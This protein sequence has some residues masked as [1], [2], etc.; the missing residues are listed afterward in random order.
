MSTCECSSSS[1]T[2]PPF[3]STDTP[4]HAPSLNPE[5]CPHPSCH[6]FEHAEHGMVRTHRLPSASTCYNMLKRQLSDGCRLLIRA[7]DVC[8][9]APHNSRCCKSIT[10]KPNPPPRVVRR[11]CPT[12]A[13]QR[14]CVR[15][16]CMPSPRAPASS[17]R[18]ACPY[19]TVS[20]AELRSRVSCGRSW[21]SKIRIKM[22]A[23][24]AHTAPFPTRGRRQRPRSTPARCGRYTDSPSHV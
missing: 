6:A 19:P 20:C 5:P 1:S 10:S 12:T 13:A 14:R 21:R 7:R 16:W 18:S 8:V 17:C 24:C 2:S 23:V 3:P 15:S 4:A 22:C 9:A 11:S